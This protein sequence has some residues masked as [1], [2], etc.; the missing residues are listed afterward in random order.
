MNWSIYRTFSFVWLPRNDFFVC[1]WLASIKIII[2][3]LSEKKTKLSLKLKIVMNLLRYK[4][5]SNIFPVFYHRDFLG[6][7]SDSERHKLELW[8][9]FSLNH[10]FLQYL[11]IL[12]NLQK[13]KRDWTKRCWLKKSSK[14]F[15][16]FIFANC[17]DLHK[18]PSLNKRHWIQNIR[19]I[20][21]WS[22][23]LKRPK[24]PLRIKSL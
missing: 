7:L 24:S 17:L 13:A 8:K 23:P 18:R 20:W 15:K 2:A 19:K 11:N 1:F 4:S 5:S 6:V 14:L 21:S 22:K 16:N 12:I 10:K 9:R 3:T